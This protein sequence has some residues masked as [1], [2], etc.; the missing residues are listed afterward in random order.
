M[1]RN[2]SPLPWYYTD[3]DAVIGSA[4]NC[5]RGGIACLGYCL[6][7]IQVM[8][9]DCDT[10]RREHAVAYASALCTALNVLSGGDDWYNRRAAEVM[11]AEGMAPIDRPS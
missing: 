10:P 9:A 5:D 8:V 7:L 11:G 6:Y 4:K 2:L 3:A 1:D